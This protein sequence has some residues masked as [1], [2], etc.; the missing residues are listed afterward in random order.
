ML[1]CAEL[2]KRGLPPVD[3]GALDQAAVF[4]EAARFA[5]QEIAYWELIVKGGFNG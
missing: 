1:E 5:W 4:T 3:G 2:L